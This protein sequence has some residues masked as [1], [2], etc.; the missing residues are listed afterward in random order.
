MTTVRQFLTQQEEITLLREALKDTLTIC[1]SRG[2]ALGLDDG[3]PVLDKARAA[4]K[5]TEW[6]GNE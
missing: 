5:A 3:G 2:T 4:L 6:S 1:I